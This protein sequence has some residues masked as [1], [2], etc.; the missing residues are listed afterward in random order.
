MSRTAPTH[1][2]YNAPVALD[3][4]LSHA[5]G[6][7]P[8]AAKAR[9]CRWV[10]DLMKTAVGPITVEAFLDG[11]FPRQNSWNKTPQLPS[12]RALE[13]VPP[14]AATPE[15]I[16]GPLLEIL[17]KASDCF[18]GFVFD[19]T[20]ARSLHPRR[21]GYMKPHICCY[22]TEN[23]DAVQRSEPQ[24]RAELGYAEFFIDVK[25]CP[26]HDYFA[27]P[28]VTS[29]TEG[30]ASHDFIAPADDQEFKKH[31]E[32]ALG[33]HIAYAIEILSRQYRVAVFSVSVAGSRTRL[34]RWDRAGCVVTEVFDL[35]E[36]ADL[37][38][39]FLWRFSQ[40][41]HR[42]RGHDVTVQVASS[43][44]ETLFREAI[45]AH[46]QFQLQ[47]DT[48][49]SLDNA[50]RQH[51]ESGH[52]AA[53]HVLAHGCPANAAHVS[54]FIVS[55][56]VVSS[57]QLTGRCTRGYWAVDTRTGDVVFLKDTWRAYP[58]V[59]LEGDTLKRM[60]DQ[61]VRN[62]PTIV[63]H[64]D[65]P[66][67]IPQDDQEVDPR[68]MQVSETDEY[69][70]DETVCK[71]MGDDVV[72]VKHWH[73]RVV[74]G[75]VGYGLGYIR[76][77]EKL[78]HATYDVFHA[79]RDAL[80]H[81]SR[82]HRDISIGNVILVREKDRDVRRGVLIDWETSCRVDEAGKAVESGRVGTWL[83]MSVD[84]LI[85]ARNDRPHTF[86]DD[87]ESLLYV[88]IY[89]GLLWLPHRLDKK[90]LAMTIGIL[91]EFSDSMT[92][93]RYGGNGKIMNRRHRI[94]TN[95]AAFSPALQDWLQTVM[96]FYR[97]LAHCREEYA[98]R[99]TNPDYLDRFW[100]EYLKT[101]VLD[102]DDRVVHDHLHANG[103]H[104][105][106]SSM[107]STEAIILR[108]RSPSEGRVTTRPLKRTREVTPPSDASLVAP[109]RSKRIR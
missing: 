74:L 87:M 102:R 42:R 38:C 5:K 107:D 75:T 14:N 67:Y 33:Q 40:S 88:I 60:N 85:N 53:V 19:S 30:R 83:F 48:E 24:L 1:C 92:P 77:T 7:E 57:L 29:T 34:L 58:P 105:A 46:V 91:F 43:D 104:K 80:R 89:C 98:D 32:R 27:D 97:P 4:T 63:C 11:F 26:S 93:G 78:L 70:K 69:Q 62:I 15:G 21:L 68:D 44:E 18:P 76:G 72:V 90:K 52:V 37:F 20:S 65:V 3:P 56:P 64:G 71:V 22:A 101:H 84:M 86:Q 6:W 36:Q 55:R 109:Q 79:M 31:R 23:F 17:K 95:A 39:E 82:L 59:D 12:Q 96:E 61:G 106:P 103:V 47:L 16:C 81:D 73:Y 10:Q 35:R 50:V 45:R 100:D 41:T 13:D 108:G 99:W 25:P 66:D 2:V 94:Y 51:Y 9:N 54:R 49:E 8:E 28:P